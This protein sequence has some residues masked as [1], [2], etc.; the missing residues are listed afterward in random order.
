MKAFFAPLQTQ[1]NYAV[2]WLS[3]LIL[4]T[5]KIYEGDQSFFVRHFGDTYS[6][7]E[8]LN[9]A[10]WLWHHMA[11]FLLWGLVPLLIVLKVFKDKAADYGL[12]LGDWRYGLKASFAALLVFPVLVYFTAQNP[13]H[14]SFYAEE[15]PLELA[16]SS[17][18]YFGLWILTYIPHY[19]GWEFFF[20]GYIGFGMKKHHGAFMA[21]MLQTLLTTLMHIGKPEGETWGAAVGGIY[22]GLLTYRTNS[23]WYSVFFHLYLGLLNSYFCSL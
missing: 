1:R 10:K 20:R 3:I 13:Q 23:I 21:I 22:F 9:W 8:H 6:N 2:L 14:K 19:I 17:M 15:F 18:L 7:T 12:T 16:T 11:T 4:M 5:I